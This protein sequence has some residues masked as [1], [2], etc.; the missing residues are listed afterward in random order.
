MTT[1]IIK[2]GAAGDVLRTTP[3]L[4]VLDGEIH[5]LTLPE[6]APLLDNG[7][8]RVFTDPGSLPQGQRY[9]RVISLEED[10]DVLR[11]V[12]QRIRADEVIGARPDE[13]GISYSESLAPWFDMSLSSSHGRGSADRRKLSNR[14]TYQE[15]IFAALGLGFRGEELL[16][17][18][19]LPTS[20]LMGDIAFVPDV[21]P[22]WPMKRWAYFEE[23][24]RHFAQSLRVTIL[25]WR[26]DLTH[27]IADIQAHR[28]I[29]TNDSL[30]MH[31]ALACRKP[32][33]A[34]FTCTSPWEIH[35]YGR[36]E[37]IVSPRLGEFFYRRDFD[38]AAT[39]AISLGEGQ[40]AIERAL[41]AANLPLHSEAELAKDSGQPML[42]HLQ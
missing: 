31:I 26:D 32:C 1:L 37:K 3:L 19:G 11:Q 36:L 25:P 34:F 38:A 7:R 5:W 9:R 29:V 12:F 21:G 14:A 8:V 22:R 40:R 17:P 4:R 30:P 15:L 16:L 20:D 2:L 27:H 33:V 10:A 24:A 35:D 28:V 6:N 23:M 39:R 18:R 13:A 41:A 42:R